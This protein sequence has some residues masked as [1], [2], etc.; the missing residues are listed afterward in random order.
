VIAVEEVPQGRV[1]MYGVVGVGERNGK[2]F[3]LSETVEKPPREKAPS[4]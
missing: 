1:H 3:S 4:N 2:L